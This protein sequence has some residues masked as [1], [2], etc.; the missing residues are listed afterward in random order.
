MDRHKFA[1]ENYTVVESCIIKPR[2]LVVLV[3][4]TISE[5]EFFGTL[6]FN[7][8]LDSISYDQ[9][10]LVAIV[11]WRL[12][13]YFSYLGKKVQQRIDSIL[14]QA[15]KTTVLI[16]NQNWNQVRQR[17]KNLYSVFRATVRELKR[18]YQGCFLTEQFR[19]LLQ[20][21]IDNIAFCIKAYRQSLI[22]SVKDFS[23]TEYIN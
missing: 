4:R 20:G 13:V 7:D 21:V 11:P 3:D 10:S 23:Q 1:L 5:S 19:Q 22:K 17:T 6:M 14:R 8:N 16:A 15:F 9:Y 18:Y 2:S 12:D